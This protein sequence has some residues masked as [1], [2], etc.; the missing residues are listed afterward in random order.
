MQHKCM[1]ITNAEDAK[2]ADLLDPS[3][4]CAHKKLQNVHVNSHH[5]LL[6]SKLQGPR[7]TEHEEKYWRE[8]LEKW[9][10]S[11]TV[12]LIIM[13]LVLVDVVNFLIT[14]SPRP[15]LSSPLLPSL[16][17]SAIIS[18]SVLVVKEHLPFVPQ[19][20]TCS[21]IG[22]NQA[23]GTG[24][25][26]PT[27]LVVTFSVLGLFFVE[28][29]LRMLAQGKRFYSSKWNFFDFIVIYSSI[30]FAIVRR[31]KRDALQK[32]HVFVTRLCHMQPHFLNKLIYLEPT[33]FPD[34]LSP[35]PWTSRFNAG[36]SRKYECSSRH[37]VTASNFF[38]RCYGDACSPSGELRVM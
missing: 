19:L 3:L 38:T 21:D 23:L 12:N 14:V 15:K 26:T 30:G 11:L 37:S 25:D 32:S 29:S 4:R 13:C 17:Y 28:L 2:K 5:W 27:Q 6:D 31:V 10:E 22:K 24:Q 16:V 1:H 36:K 9:L 7:G 34:Q 35:T 20:R 18:Q 8:M 33:F